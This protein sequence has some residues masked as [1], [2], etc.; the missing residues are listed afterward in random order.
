MSQSRIRNTATQRDAHS[1]RRKYVA[2]SDLAQGR[3][4]RLP[5]S[6]TALGDQLLFAGTSWS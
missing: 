4:H 6:G 1:L 2:Y 5:G 3:N